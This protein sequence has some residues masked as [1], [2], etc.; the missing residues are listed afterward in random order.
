MLSSNEEDN[1]PKADTEWINM[2]ELAISYE[3]RGWV[4][5]QFTGLKD[6]NG[7]EI[8]EGDIV[9]FT[10]TDGW[11][12]HRWKEKYAHQDPEGTLMHDEVAFED[13]AF[14]FKNKDIEDN[15]SFANRHAEYCV[16]IGNVWLNPELLNDE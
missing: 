2:T 14:V 7:K 9:E 10:F 11:P 16:V 15:Y 4:L 8:Y 12:M 5:M 13:G 6:K 1:G 3:R